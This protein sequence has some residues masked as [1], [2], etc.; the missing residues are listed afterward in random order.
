MVEGEDPVEYFSRIDKTVQKLAML[1]GTKDDD[2][3]NVH[4]AQNLSASHEVEKKILLSSPGL[5]RSNIEEVVRNAYMSHKQ[6]VRRGKGQSKGDDPHALYAVSAQPA[7][8]GGNGM[9]RGSKGKQKNRQRQQ[10]QEQSQ[11][12]QSQQQQQQR[13][14][15]SG[16]GGVVGPTYRLD[17]V[18]GQWRWDD[19]RLAPFRNAGDVPPMGYIPVQPP[20][21]ALPPRPR[22]PAGSGPP[23]RGTPIAPRLCFKCQQPGHYAAQF[24]AHAHAHVARKYPP[25]SGYFGAHAASFNPPPAS[26]DGNWQAGAYH[27]PYGAG[28]Y[29]PTNYAPRY[30]AT[31]ATPYA[32]STVYSQYDP[33]VAA[34]STHSSSTSDDPHVLT[35]QTAQPIQYPS[36]MNETPRDLS[37]GSGGDEWVADSGASYHVMGDPTGVFDCKPPLVGKERLVIGDM[38]MMG[39]QCFGNLSLLMHGQGGDTHVRLTNLAYVPGVQFN[40]FSLHAVMSKRRVTMD[41]KGD[42]M[43]GGSVSFVRREAGSYCSATRITDP[44]MASAVL[45]PDKQQR[46]DINGLHVALAHPHAETLRETAR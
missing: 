2:D 29:D 4:I 41:T 9:G 8:A 15:Q 16:G 46:I 12:Q 35:V 13:Q 25:S 31:A 7:G 36:E 5:T 37:G 11:Q 14:H 38:T 22:P 26:H 45:I 21:G 32:P 24:T 1:G 20:P 44:P 17:P 18:Y 42:H 30:A 10:K 28:G 3:V 6:N 19:S 23:R 33:Q 40:L 27:E 39:V 34:G 43:L